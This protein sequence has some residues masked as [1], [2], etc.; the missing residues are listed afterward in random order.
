[1][2]SVQR[3]R[4][5][6]DREVS[7]GDIS[8]LEATIPMR[9]GKQAPIADDVTIYAFSHDADLAGVLKSAARDQFSARVVDEWDDLLGWSSPRPVAA[10]S[11]YWTSM[12]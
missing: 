4:L 6:R 3:T 8:A 12:H 2:S 7:L 1:M 9:A 10:E 5:P 11:C